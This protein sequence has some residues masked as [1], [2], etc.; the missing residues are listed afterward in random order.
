MEVEVEGVVDE[1]EESV[2]GME[3]GGCGDEVEVEVKVDAVRLEGVEGL[4]EL[5][6]GAFGGIENRRSF[7]IAR[8]NAQEEVK[9]HW[10]DASRWLHVQMTCDWPC[11]LY[12]LLIQAT[13]PLRSPKSPIYSHLLRLLYFLSVP[14]PPKRQSNADALDV[15][16][17]FPFFLYPIRSPMHPFR[18]LPHLQSSGKS[19]L[20]IG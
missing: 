18:S 15:T 16:Y 2:D 8:R 11:M 9:I 6:A 4:E 7:R 13:F 5:E 12:R 1:E 17:K 20:L 3:V 14:W 19:S 10:L